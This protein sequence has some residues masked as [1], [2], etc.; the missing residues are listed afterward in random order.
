MN[1]LAGSA[2]RYGI[3]A[4][5]MTADRLDSAVLDLAAVLEGLVSKDFEIIVV[6]GSSAPTEAVLEDVRARAP[7]LPLRLVEGTT[8]AAGC[9]AAAYDLIFVCAPDGRFDVREL[10]RL[11]EAIEAGADV[12]TGFRPHRTDGL[13]RQLQ[14]W[15]CH[16]DL[17]HAFSLLNRSVWNTLALQ[18]NASSGEVILGARRLG[19]QVAEIR[20]SNR[21]PAIGA[22]LTAGSRAA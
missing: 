6:S 8:V 5:L 13:L 19:Y 14:R 17:D 7:A 11:F 1:S 3:S 12:A 10:N 22:A 2:A 18:P 9:D 4:V 16:V 20:V 21:R 15:G